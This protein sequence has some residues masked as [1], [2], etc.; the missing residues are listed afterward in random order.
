M[1]DEPTPTPEPAPAAP[2][3][4]TDPSTIDDRGKD[5]LVAQLADFRKERRGLRSRVA[6]IEKALDE[7]TT[8]ASALAGQLETLQ[9][10]HAEASSAW[11]DER[12]MLGVGLTDPEGQAV[13]RTLYG[14]QPEDSRP[15]SIADYLSGFQAE[16]AKVPA[17]LAPYLGKA[18]PAQPNP[19]PAQQEPAPSNGKAT[20][21]LAKAAR[22]SGNF[23]EL[24]RLLNIPWNQGT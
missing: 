11:A 22:E 20:D 8:S 2:V 4:P 7:R 18:A 9:A 1:S 23:A 13:A 24:A 12:A 3:I 16:D 15:G 17:G 5:A 19:A 21:A 14:L 10:Q 6:E